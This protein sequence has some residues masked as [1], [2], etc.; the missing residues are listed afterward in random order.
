MKLL[1]WEAGGFT[2]YYKRLEKGT[3]ELPL[4]DMK[5]SRISWPEL[6]M[7][8]EGIPLSIRKKKVRFSTK[9]HLKAW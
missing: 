7:I 9:N 2:L 1:H 4:Q 6:V 3:L 5:D 8:I